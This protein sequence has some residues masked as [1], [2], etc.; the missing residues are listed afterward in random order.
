VRRGTL[1]VNWLAIYAVAVAL[2]LILPEL[3]AVIVS[4]NPTSRM[5]M[6]WTSFSGRWYQSL[7]QHEEYFWAFLLSFAIAPFV[8][9]ASLLLGGMAAYGAARLPSR[10]A[11]VLQGLFVAPL[12]VPAAALAVALF[13]LL[14]RLRLTDT[15]VGVFI[16]HIV[17]T[18]PYTFRTLLAALKAADRALEEAALSLGASRLAVV[19]RVTLPLIRPALVASALFALIVSI[20]EFTLTWFISGRSIHTIPL[21]IFNNTQYGMD[22]TVAAASTVLI[23]VS[24]LVIVLLEKIVGLKAAYAVRT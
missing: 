6:S 9:A 3:V 1:R 11:A 5:V 19:R 12:V 8:T 15:L 17:A 20:D 24:A 2:F 13:L 16:G 14:D 22:P 21:E 10:P 7:W 4:F 23:A 18:L